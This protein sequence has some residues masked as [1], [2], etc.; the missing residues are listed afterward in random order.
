MMQ[1]A[2]Q[3]MPGE[4]AVISH[5]FKK[6]ED[7]WLKKLSGELVK[8]SFPYDYKRLSANETKT[9]RIKFNIPGSLFPKLMKL[10]GGS[11]LK[12]FMILVTAL[13]VLVHKYTGNK[14]IIVGAPIF[15][16]DVDEEFI[17]TVVALRNQLTDNMTFK[18][19]LLQV[20]ESIIEADEHQNYSI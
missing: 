11:D 1:T 10:S 14:D 13:L 9:D 17:N 4:A 8:T 18:E 12:L 16:Q 7:Y 2:T 3:M 5:Q 20:R 19:L 6:E 15:K